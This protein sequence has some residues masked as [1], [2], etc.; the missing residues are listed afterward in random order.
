M[1]LAT[2]SPSCAYS[3]DGTE[4]DGDVITLHLVDGKRGDDILLQDGMIIDQ[5]GP[6]LSVSDSDGASTS[7][8]GGGGGC[9]IGTA[10]DGMML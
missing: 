9:F 4:I 2:E 6:G 5:G 7:G 1:L 10:G 8:G 3:Q